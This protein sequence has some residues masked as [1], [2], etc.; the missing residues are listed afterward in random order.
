M[1][2][3]RP[4]REAKVVFTSDLAKTESKFH[5]GTIAIFIAILRSSMISEISIPKHIPFQKLK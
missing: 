2:P 3:G 1:I 4:T 5:P